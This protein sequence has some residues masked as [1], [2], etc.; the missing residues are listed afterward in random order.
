MPVTPGSGSPAPSRPP[1][2]DDIP[3]R[4]CS[5]VQ[6]YDGLHR[7]YPELV[8]PRSVDELRAVLL[9]AVRGRRRVTFRA[10]GQS[11]DGQSLNEDMV[12]SMSRFDAI[13]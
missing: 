5:L 1:A 2:L 6:S 11:F 4:T 10:G 12:I 8:E 3:G 9:R 7:A 13:E